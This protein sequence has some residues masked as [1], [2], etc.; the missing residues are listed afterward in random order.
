MRRVLTENKTATAKIRLVTA[1][2]NPAAPERSGEENAVLRF[3]FLIRGQQ[4][5]LMV[6]AGSNPCLAPKSACKKALLKGELQ[7]L[8]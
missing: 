6:N 2:S 8:T 4:Q 5:K 1:G 7:C 3:G